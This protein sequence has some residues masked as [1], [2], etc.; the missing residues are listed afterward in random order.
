MVYRIGWVGGYWLVGKKKTVEE[1]R[2]KQNKNKRK[3]MKPKYA[4]KD[5]TECKKKFEKRRY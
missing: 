5:T 3:N 1:E 2:G 4:G